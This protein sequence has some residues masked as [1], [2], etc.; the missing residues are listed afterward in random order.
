MPEIEIP[1]ELLN[2]LNELANK[3]GI[4]IND[5]INNILNK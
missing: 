2:E 1:E 5:L 4:T 3:K